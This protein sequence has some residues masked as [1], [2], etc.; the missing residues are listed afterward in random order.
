M[1]IRSFL[2]AVLIPRLRRMMQI[3]MS[4]PIPVYPYG[5]LE[6]FCSYP[7][8]AP[9]KA[10]YVEHILVATH[11]GD[12]G[13]AE[14][15]R[16]L[17]NRLRDSTW[18]IVFKALIIVHLMIREGEPNLTLKFLADSPSKLAIS[19]FSDGTSKEYSMA[20]AKSPTQRGFL[21]HM[22]RGLWLDGQNIDMLMVLEIAVQVQGTNIRHYYNYILARAKAF[23][24]TRIDWVRE[25]VGRL[26]RQ[27]VDK[28]LLREMEAVQNQINSLL[29][30]DLLSTE[31]ENEITVCA[32]R[33]LTMDLLVLYVVM[34]EGTINV[35]EHYFEM[36]KFDAQRALVI[37][38][39]FTKQTNLVVEFLGTAR[40]Y[41]NATR[42]EIPK[43]KHA[44][45]SLTSSLEEY[46]NDPDFEINRRQYL[47]HQDAKKGRK[48]TGNG[49][50]GSSDMLKKQ[51]GNMASKSSFLPESKI[52]QQS[53]ASSATA[54]KG[55]APDLIDFFGSIE[56]NQQPMASQVQ[57]QAPSFQNTAQTGPIP[58]QN[59]YAQQPP[60]PQLNGG[61]FSD[62]SPFGQLQ[63]QQTPFQNLTGAGFGGYNQQP[64]AQQQD[65]FSNTS[66]A[67]GPSFPSQQQP[68]STGQTSF[69][70]TQQTFNTGQSP[71][72]T[73]PF[74]QSMF[75]QSTGAPSP[76]YSSPPPMPQPQS[77]LSTNPFAPQA[78]NQSS[79]M[80]FSQMPNQSSPFTSS[81]PQQPQTRPLTSPPP[82]QAQQLPTEHIIPQRTG[83]NPFARSTAPAPQ[84]Q[85]PTQP[86]VASTTGTNPFRQSVFVNPQ[87]GQWQ[88]GQ[89]TMGGLE[90][91]ETM[92]VFPRPGQQTQLTQLPRSP[93]LS[94][95]HRA[96]VEDLR[97][98][99]AK[100]Y[101]V[102]GSL[103]KKVNNTDTYSFHNAVFAQGTLNAKDHGTYAPF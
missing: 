40:R 91:L 8:L 61:A 6:V 33:L 27:S 42:L 98:R 47:A 68:F 2:K 1:I 93:C 80:P 15:F 79:V 82:Q 70:S 103:S 19:N 35:L 86:L 21:Y 64:F 50:P 71:S 7:A 28:G 41:E 26:K 52:S 24:D 9:P 88:A 99:R 56:Q 23:R 96:G 97:E 62:N 63:Q 36:S 100:M 51:A 74:R 75:P 78:G 72:S 10:K 30:C 5:C 29:K 59:Y 53:A 102:C 89:G 20:T 39:T 69:S 34:N 85:P 31:A 49:G 48:N 55:P 32:F 18:T 22:R 45:T 92:P 13:V 67:T 54:P 11:A 43:L 17:Q 46:L 37:Y 77:P 87:I 14:I 76:S 81:A 58:Q 4:I 95:R 57:Q 94:L 44:P 3:P 90:N 66:Q 60:G 73:N 101:D 83:T 12:A 25:G 16:A 84:S 65:I 38:K